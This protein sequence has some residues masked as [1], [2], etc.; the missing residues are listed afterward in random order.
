MECALHHRCE[1]RVVL[2]IGNPVCIVRKEIAGDAKPGA[3]PGFGNHRIEEHF[4]IG[5]RIG[6]SRREEFERLLMI[7]AGDEICAEALLF[8]QRP[9]RGRIGGATRHCHGFAF[10]VDATCEW[11]CPSGQAASYR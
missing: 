10:E 1:C 5:K 8:R 3:T 2:R 11:N 9:D 6:L 7:V 4:V